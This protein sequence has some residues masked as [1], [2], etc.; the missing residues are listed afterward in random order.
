MPQ[1][2]PYS[3]QFDFADFSAAFPSDQQPGPSLEAEFNAVA[4]TLGGVLSNLKQIQRDDGKLANASV[5]LD[6]LTPAALLSLG[7]GSSWTPRGEWEPLLAYQR[8]DVVS[9]DTGT[10]VAAEAHDAALDFASDSHLWVKIFDDA[11]ATPAEGSV[12][13]SS[14]AAGAVTADKIGFD[15]LALPG[16]FLAQG[17]LA[18]GTATP[19]AFIINARAAGG[20]VHA[21]IARADREQ[22]AVGVRIDGGVGGKVWLIEQAD[23]ADALNLGLANAIPALSISALGSISASGTMRVTGKV[24]PV[25]GAGLELSY[26]ASYADV[27]AFDRDGGKFKGLRLAGSPVAISASNVDVLVADATGVAMTD[28]KIGGFPAGWRGMPQVAK[29]TAYELVANDAGRHI[30]ITQGGVLIP[31]NSKVAFPVGTRIAIFN[32]SSVAQPINISADTLRH[33]G[34]NITGRWEL[35][36]FDV[37]TLMKVAPTVWVAGSESRISMAKYA[38]LGFERFSDGSY[39]M[40][41]TFLALPKT[42]TEFPYNNIDSRIVLAQFSRVVVSGGESNPSQQDNPPA[43][44]AATNGGFGVFNATGSYITTYFRAKGK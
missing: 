24:D 40:W 42:G 16:T 29:T 10:Y 13:T 1:P 26:A 34:G 6:S 22:G 18:A 33:A 44:T 17:G 15:A 9:Y 7:A 3:R 27:R 41:G 31:A 37:L 39:E 14:I 20:N 11:G 32:N 5:T 19:G 30:S 2:T 12:V 4:K 21:N 8:F 25:G 38:S 28:A 36:P 35:Q 43:V 23:D